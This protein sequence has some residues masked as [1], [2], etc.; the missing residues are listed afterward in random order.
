MPL[1]TPVRALAPPSAGAGQTPPAGARDEHGG[2]S[3]VTR[4]AGPARVT[5]SGGPSGGRRPGVARVRVPR[6]G[7]GPV[8]APRRGPARRPPGRLT[9]GGAVST[10]ARRGV[11]GRVVGGAPGA[12]GGGRSLRVAR[13]PRGRDGGTGAAAVGLTGG[14]CF[15]G[16]GCQE[17]H[18]SCSR[19]R[20][21][22][23]PD[24]HGHD[25]S[26]LSRCRSEPIWSESGVESERAGPTRPGARCARDVA[27]D[28]GH[29]A[30]VGALGGCRARHEPVQRGRGLA[31]RSAGWDGDGD[32]ESH[33]RLVGQSNSS[34][35]VR[36]PPGGSTVAQVAAGIDS[37]TTF[38]DRRARAAGADRG[39][40]G[41]PG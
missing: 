5:G 13:R 3:R 12:A 10:V 30:R 34:E 4:R 6:T 22:R 39:R 19:G 7:V 32:R 23:P 31:A 38:M 37:G 18:S 17:E 24:V 25:E 27:G 15:S 21:E 29:G 9:G 36:E 11:G 28:R 2:S 35:E 16:A 40:A 20:P 41:R 14:S 1:L 8:R 33:N 26:I